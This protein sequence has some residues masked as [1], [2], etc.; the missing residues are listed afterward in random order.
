MSK[1][2]ADQRADLARKIAQQRRWIE[3]HG[4]DRAG[5]IARYGQ[6][7]IKEP[8]LGGGGSAIYAADKAELDRLLAEDARL[9]SRQNSATNLQIR[10]QADRAARPAQYRPI[11]E[12]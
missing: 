4:T 9:L 11:K 6:A 2:I 10:L 3:E 12:S 1:S 7:G 5:Y 8:V